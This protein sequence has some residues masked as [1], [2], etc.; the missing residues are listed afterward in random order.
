MIDNIYFRQAELLL[1]V[2]PLVDR[3]AVFALKGGTAI[4]FFV[5]DLP[6]VSVDIDLV[7]LPVGE[8][9]LSLRE[10]SDAMVRISR[11]VENRIP[12]T[13]IFPKKLKGFDLWSGCSIQR[14]DA[15]IK[16]EP[17]LVIRGSLFPNELYAGKIC[18]ALDRQHPRDLFD[19]L[20]FLRE[21]T[22]ND[23]MRK[24]FIVYLI[25]HDRPMVEILDPRFADIRP[26]FEAEF[27]D[28]TLEEATCEDLE[29]TREQLVSMITSVLTIQERQFIVSIK[30]GIPQW[31]LIG[32]EGVQNLPAV[33]WKLMN[34]GRMAPAKHQQALRKLRDYLDV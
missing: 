14:E 15:T 28:M 25:S 32:L 26:V 6:R 9:D 20:I 7:Y 27:R 24:A 10:I 4:N 5:R 34:I 16:I 19:V 21:G 31:D 30:E 2:L 8:R 29:K 22:F 18:A 17:N 1:R 11:N 33:Q 23:A 13:K 12:G 3:E